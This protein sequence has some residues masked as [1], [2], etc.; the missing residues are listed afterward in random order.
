MGSTTSARLS[1]IARARLAAHI[2]R[3][4]LVVRLRMNREPLPQLVARVGHPI[5][6]RLDYQ[7]PLRLSRAVDRS[8]R[9]GGWRPA[10]LVNAL[11]LF[12]LLREQG[13]MAEL[14]IGLPASASDHI[15]HAW[16][17]VLGVDVGPPPGRS[18]HTPLARF[19]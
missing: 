15:A 19:K 11:V 9:L 4:F 8:L 7:P 5:R 18:Q 10:C 6:R 17:E 16:V 2:W 1:L 3:W 14:V 12:R 13:D